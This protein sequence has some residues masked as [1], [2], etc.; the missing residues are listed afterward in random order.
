MCK[1]STL[2]EGEDVNLIISEPGYAA[3]PQC[4]AKFEENVKAT[5]LG[6]EVE[7]GIT[8]D[9]FE[10]LEQRYCPDCDIPINGYKEICQDNAQTS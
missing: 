8:F 7:N 3:C 1:F 6:H 2:D 4:T 10:Y 5:Y 9:T